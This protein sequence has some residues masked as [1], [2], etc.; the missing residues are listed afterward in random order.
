M[1]LEPDDDWWEFRDVD[2]LTWRRLKLASLH[3]TCPTTSTATNRSSWKYSSYLRCS[4]LQMCT[5]CR[6]SC[7]F[8]SCAA[9][10]WMAFEKREATGGKWIT[11]FGIRASTFKNKDPDCYCAKNRFTGK[12]AVEIQST[13]TVSRL[14]HFAMLGYPRGQILSLFF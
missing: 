14:L 6:K 5:R 4:E 12:R 11:L 2:R 9:M 1:P 10:H 8:Y 3:R 13:S 7:L